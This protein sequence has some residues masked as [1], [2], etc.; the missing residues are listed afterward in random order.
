VVAYR[1]EDPAIGGVLVCAPCLAVWP[2]GFGEL[3]SGASLVLDGIFHSSGEL[4][5]GT[6]AAGSA[7]RAMGHLPMTGPGGTLTRISRHRETHPAARWAYTHLNNTSP[8][9]DPGSPEH[10]EVLAACVEL[11]HDGTEFKL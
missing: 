11:P 7:Q 5:D 9:L 6:C 3:I 10:N 2:D 8:V 1:I 4:S